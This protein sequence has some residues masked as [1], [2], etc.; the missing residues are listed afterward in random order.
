[1]VINNVTQDNVY[2]I[3]IDYL[4]NFSF[5]PPK[6]N[7]GTIKIE[8]PDDVFMVEFHRGCVY[9]NGSSIP[10]NDKIFSDWKPK[11]Q[12]QCRCPYVFESDLMS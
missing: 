8:N 6:I 12:K 5:N 9:Y 4:G 2:F 11:F 10:S 7:N 3:I 1:M